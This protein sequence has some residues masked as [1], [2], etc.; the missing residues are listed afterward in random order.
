MKTGALVVLICIF[1]AFARSEEP[2]E[3]N[4]SVLESQEPIVDDQNFS[5]MYPEQPGEP[6]DEQT[7]PAQEESAIDENHP[8]PTIELEASST[9]KVSSHQAMFKAE[10]MIH[11]LSTEQKLDIIG[12]AWNL[13]SVDERKDMVTILLEGDDSA[14]VPEDTYART[15]DAANIKEVSSIPDYH[16]PA[17]LLEV[18]SN[19]KD[20]HR[21]IFLQESVWPT[22]P[23][24]SQQTVLS[25]LQVS[26]TASASPP[27]PAAPLP[28]V[29]CGNPNNFAQIGRACHKICSSDKDCSPAGNWCSCDK[30]ATPNMA[31]FGVC[32]CQC[33]PA[34]YLTTSACKNVPSTVDSSRL[35]CLEYFDYGICGQSGAVSVGSSFLLVSLSV[36]ALLLL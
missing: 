31:P 34:K 8:A 24:E 17:S 29:N 13:A 28:P 30:R 20:I 25:F 10:S 12:H 2:D 27:P 14:E 9:V 1:L 4:P 5:T 33:D 15:Y 11:R 26:S 23:A 18:Y 22:L 3:Q 16:A 6:I 36:V 35:V 7:P 32:T 21:L 19:M